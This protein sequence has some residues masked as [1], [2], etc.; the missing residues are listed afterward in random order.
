MADWSSIVC[1]CHIFIHSSVDGHLGCFRVLAIVNSAGMN[2]EVRVS[3]MYP[4]FI[5][6]SVDEHLGCFCILAIMSSATMNI[7]VCVSFG[8]VLIFNLWFVMVTAE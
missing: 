5:H 4:I 3:Y 8:A 2:I 6:S 1:M 7:E